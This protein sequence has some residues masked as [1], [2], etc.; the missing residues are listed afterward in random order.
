VIKLNF[1]FSL[2]KLLVGFTTGI[3]MALTHFAPQS[4]SQLVTSLNGVD[5]WVCTADCDKTYCGNAHPNAAGSIVMHPK[6]C[7][8]GAIADCELNHC[9][10]NHWRTDE[11]FVTYRARDAKWAAQNS[12][13]CS[14]YA[15]EIEFDQSYWALKYNS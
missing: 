5:R 11:Q 2:P 10:F 15:D 3:I 7:L 12:T 9:P 13:R 8:R 1:L 6:W 4:T 14:Q